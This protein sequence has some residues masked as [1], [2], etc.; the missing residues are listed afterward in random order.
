MNSDAMSDSGLGFRLSQ[1]YSLRKLEVSAN[2]SMLNSV[3]S[4]S[5]VW[6]AVQ[7]LRGILGT[8]WI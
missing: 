7:P 2:V 6:H 4:R 3:K 5:M 8:A 1:I